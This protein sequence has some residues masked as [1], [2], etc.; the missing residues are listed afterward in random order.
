MS[1]SH[2]DEAMRNRL[3]KHLAMLVREGVIETWHD[4]RIVPGHPLDGSI[5]AEVETADLFLFLLS[6]DFLASNYC[7]DVEMRRALERHAAGEAAILPVVLHSYEWKRTPLG[8][9]LGAPQDGKPIA[10][11]AYQEDAYLEV[12]EAIRK[13]VATL[14]PS[15][16]HRAGSAAT[17]PVARSQGGQDRLAGAASVGAM[18]RPAVHP[19]SSNLAIRKTF[20]DA[21]RHA[22]LEDGFEFIARFFEETLAELEHR[23]P[24]VEAR[25]RRNGADTFTA[26]AF[27]D[28]KQEAQCRVQFGGGMMSGNGISFSHDANAQPGSYNEYLSV[29]SDDQGL[30]FDAIGMSAMTGREPK[31]LT[32][33]GAAEFL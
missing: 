6:A 14:G 17:S 15:A 18:T 30:M 3:E 1:Y 31:G 19:R 22:F 28:G 21:D 2:A 4:R 12:A 16:P 23:N 13:A 20:T 8:K 10:K 25:F 11:Y 33:Q 32:P 7:Y 26:R 24:G 9:I 29:K 5:M 27:R